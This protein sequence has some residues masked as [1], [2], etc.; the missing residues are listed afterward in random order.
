MSNNI[1][2]VE[3]LSKAYRLG[4]LEGAPDTL[5]AAV[6]G[7]LSSPLRGLR[8]LRRLDTQGTA[9]RAGDDDLF[10]ALRDVSFNVAEG[11]VVGI[12][13]R[14][15]AGKSSLL[16]ILSR[17]TEPT[18]GGAVIDGRVSSLL[19][20]GT[21]FHP[22]LTG[23]EN[24]FMNGTLLGMS[25]AEID[26]KF[27]EIVDF[28]GVSR[29][30]DTPTKRYSSGM[31]VRLAFA[32]AA[33]LEPEILVI[34]EVLAVGDTEFQKR[35]LGKMR[36]VASSGRTVL[37]VSH[38][39]ESI[40]RLC[41]RGLL[42]DEGRLVIDGSVEQAIDGYL[43]HVTTPEKIWEHDPPGNEVVQLLA[44][45]AVNPQ[46]QVGKE[47]D[48]GAPVEVQITYRVLES[49]NKLGAHA[50]FFTPDG[51]CVFVSHDLDPEWLDRRR[52]VGQYVSTVTIPGNFL[53]EGELT[54][55]VAFVTYHPFTVHMFERDTVGF[56]ITETPEG[57]A[58]RG[59]HNRA[60]E[61]L[62]RP[63][64]AWRTTAP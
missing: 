19:E 37:F 60:M 61:G 12:V 41:S 20:V 58:A 42:L 33:H 28:S 56:R 6:K 31:L 50:H 36:S 25:K 21:G 39:M 14:N 38:Q 34:D 51:T 45:R 43:A 40:S 26:K 2:T 3:S 54:V 24:V 52:P 62:V 7:W 48:I 55:G 46:G 59:P 11:D 64:L 10:W 1:M 8:K 63:L 13:G 57:G 32:V 16:K 22:E 15:G 44:V 29:F 27:D 5:F 23:R 4:Q 35:C 17:I 47:F 18:R 49:G 9:E 30:L 53:S